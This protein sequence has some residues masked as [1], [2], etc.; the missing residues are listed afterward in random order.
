MV[1]R[2]AGPCSTTSTLCL[3][4]SSRCSA[5]PTS[6]SVS[7]STDLRTTSTASGSQ[8]SQSGSS[9]TFSSDSPCASATNRGI[10]CPPPTRPRQAINVLHN[11][12]TMNPP[13]RSDERILSPLEFS[14]PV[15]PYE[16]LVMFS[17]LSVRFKLSVI[18]NWEN[19]HDHKENV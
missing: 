15:S 9:S 5:S 7:D 3:G 13:S 11:C 17:S 10:A 18:K 2:A 19:G 14:H 1:C 6:G 4:T 12:Q 16:S 8:P